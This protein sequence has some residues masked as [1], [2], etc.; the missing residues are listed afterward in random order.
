[1]TKKQYNSN[2]SK[3]YELV[4][5]HVDLINILNESNPVST[6][7]INPNQ[8]LIVSFERDGKE[9]RSIPIRGAD[10][11]T[12]KFEVK[13]SY[14]FEEDFC[15]LNVLPEC[16]NS[17]QEWRDRTGQRYGC[18]IDCTSGL[19]VCVDPAPDPS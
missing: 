17:V 11:L 14:D 9:V 2:S 4:F 12:V 18:Y 16:Y 15:D 10:T 5:E 6:T 8:E 13:E 3:S 19:T 1:M 7:P